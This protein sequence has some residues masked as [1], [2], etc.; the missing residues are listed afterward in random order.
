MTTTSTSFFLVC[1]K[2]HI[3]PMIDPK[4]FQLHKIDVDFFSSQTPRQHTIYVEMQI[5]ENDFLIT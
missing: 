2:Q 4:L 5:S 1:Q 3:F